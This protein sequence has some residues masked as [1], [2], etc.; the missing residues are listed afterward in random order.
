MMRSIVDVESCGLWL[1]WKGR[2]CV[3]LNLI[4]RLEIDVLIVEVWC[5][6]IEDGT[7][8]LTIKIVRQSYLKGLP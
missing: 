3:T 1:M 8:E 6:L 4:H 5:H 2:C 7:I